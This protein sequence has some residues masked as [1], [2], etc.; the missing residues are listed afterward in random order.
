V[1]ALV[2]APW[3]YGCTRPWSIQVLNVL[4]GCVVVFWLAG[5]AVRRKWPRVPAVPLSLALLL[6]AQAWWMVLNAKSD[7][8][9]T[10]LQYIPLPHWLDW[11]P[12][13]LH[14]S[15][16]LQIAIHVTALLGAGCFCCELGSRP[17]W[18]KRLLRIIT[19]NGVVWVAFGLIQRLTGAQ[20]IFWGPGDQGSTFFGTY[21]YHANAGAFI[22]LVWPLATG[23]FLLAL[24]SEENPRRKKVWGLA[25]IVCTAGV[26]VNASRAANVIA[27]ALATLWLGWFIWKRRRERERSTIKPATL[28]IVSL[29]LVIFLAGVAA[30]GGFDTSLRRWSKFNEELTAR[31]P[32]LLVAEVCMGML[33]DAGA[34]GFG[35][36]TFKTVFPY[37][38]GELG[39]EISGVWEFAHD[40]YL[41]TLVEWGMIGGGFWAI[42]LF[43]AMAYP[44]WLA[45]RNPMRLNSADRLTLFSVWIALFG[46]VVHAGMDYPFQIASIQLH[47]VALLG[48]LWSCRSWMAR[49]NPL[50]R[51][52]RR[53]RDREPASLPTRTRSNPFEDS[54]GWRN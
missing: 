26:F 10:A 18:R 40:D 21:R 28:I 24:R 44:C 51:L 17:S 23:F 46:L 45:A 3:A 9:T 16:S 20:G 6:I 14:K 5:C 53:L 2:Y 48:I 13:S 49:V 15:A 19:V 37:Y 8:D 22:N 43:G 34:C 54:E 11:A 7:Y 30:F 27:L 1:G 41:Q 39:D 36:G 38:T 32:R 42:Y 12:G 35:P 29:S 31:N 52:K 25:L 50:G 47:A 4:L 33:P